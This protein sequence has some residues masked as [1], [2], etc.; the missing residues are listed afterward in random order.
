MAVSSK[1]KHYA[2]RVGREGPKIY[3]NWKETERVTRN[4]PYAQHKSFTTLELAQKYLDE[5]D[6]K[7]KLNES[8]ILKRVRN[9]HHRTSQEEDE[10][11]EIPSQIIIKKKQKTD[12]PSS[13][14]PTQTPKSNSISSSFVDKKPVIN[15]TRR[16][17]SVR[18][19]VHSP[20]DFDG[21]SEDQ[22]KVFKAVIAGG[23]VFFTG[24]AGTGKSHLLKKIIHHFRTRTRKEIHVTA[25]T[26]IAASLIKGTTLHSFSGLGLANDTQDKLYFKIMAN[27]FALKRW[28]SVDVLIIDEVSMIDG[29]F[30]DKLNQLAKRF[31]C[32]IDPFGGIQLILTGDFFQLPPVTKPGLHVKRL[33]YL[34]ESESW[35]EC[36][37]KIIVLKHVFRQS[38]Q[39]FV[40]LL[41]EIRVGLVSP[42][43][44][45]IM[46]SLTKPVKY[47]DGIVPTELYPRK[48]DV[49]EANQFH[50]RNLN[51]PEK[52]FDCED[53]RTS[54]CTISLSELSRNLD[55]NTLASHKLILKLGAQVMLI[56]NIR[57]QKLVN[58][59]VGIVIGFETDRNSNPLNDDDQHD[60]Q[61]SKK[62]KT[63]I[64]DYFEPI[65]TDSNQV[66]LWPKVKFT[67]GQ[68]IL[69]IPHEFEHE[70]SQGEV[71]GVRQQVP[72][73]LAWA[74]SIHKSQGQSLDRVK[75][76]LGRA[77]EAVSSAFFFLVLDP[78]LTN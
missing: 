46:A 45:E 74:L 49:A 20:P 55:R 58:G 41:N 47:D 12:T 24:S 32:N 17:T 67:S 42:Q 50:L 59:S 16:S 64:N 10:E 19:I 31:R 22:T 38:D 62:S 77:F 68:T 35:E 26:G 7:T 5:H 27:E 4:Y 54:S 37:D 28:Q 23:S 36:V 57:D 9:Q 6:T 69:L 60:L 3:D 44:K 51:Q 56:K 65:N 1:Q 61:T 43:T 53:S 30:F 33:P 71:I 18:P 52:V 75:I 78:R 63:G 11:E 8:Q 15:N 72:L 21:L 34:F 39:V 40:D 2:V 66:K 76:D 73:I 14:E 29:E 25:S 70:N 48:V 13:T